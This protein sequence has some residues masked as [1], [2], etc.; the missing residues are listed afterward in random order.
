MNNNSNPANQNQKNTNNKMDSKKLNSSDKRFWIA[1]AAFVILVALVMWDNNHRANAPTISS[2]M[3]SSISSTSVETIASEPEASSTEI[4]N[5]SCDS[6]KNIVTVFHLPKDDFVNLRL[7]DGRSMILAH[8]IS[9]DG[10]RYANANESFVFWTK[11]V[12][13][14]VLENGTTTYNGCIANRFP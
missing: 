11:G 14:F 8:A 5:Y 3:T 6:G 2:E 10:A 4:Y 13:A 9:A 7:S 1:I 12:T